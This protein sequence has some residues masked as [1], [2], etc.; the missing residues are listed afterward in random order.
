M[1]P[2]LYGYIYHILKAYAQ[3]LRDEYPN[4][5]IR[6][7][8]VFESAIREFSRYGYIEL[9]DGKRGIPA[10]LPD[11]LVRTI[12]R[13]KYKPIWMP[14]PNYPYSGFIS[15]FLRP[16]MKRGKIVWHHSKKG[17]KNWWKP[18]WQP[19]AENKNQPS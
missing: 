6:N 16:S 12:K 2:K 1:K 18:G 19:G 10:W 13:V 17:N 3:R 11:R 4:L 9:V 14:G 15:D 8:T 5:T 7:A